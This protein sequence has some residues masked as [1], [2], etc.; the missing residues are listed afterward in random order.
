MRSPL[1]SGGGGLPER[2]EPGRILL[3][4]IDSIGEERASRLGEGR[5]HR[6]SLLV[7]RGNDVLTEEAQLQQELLRAGAPRLLSGGRT[8]GAWD[9]ADTQRADASLVCGKGA[10]RVTVSS[11][12]TAC[13][14]R[15][16]HK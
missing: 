10:S 7:N 4:E 14:R 2:V 3:L 5:P 1:A 11:H 12:C 13:A 8:T 9:M 16:A 6:C 15:V